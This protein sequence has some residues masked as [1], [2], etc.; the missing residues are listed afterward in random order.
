MFKSKFIAVVIL[1]GI[2]ILGCS[3]KPI[4]QFTNPILAGFYP[5]PSLCRVGEDYYLVTSTFSYF[6]GI[7][8]F[9][10]KDLVNWE[11][12]GHVL[13]RPEQLDTEGLGI[14][15]GIFAPA[16]TYSNGTFYVSCTVVDGGGNFIVTSAKPE[17][18]Y[19]DPIWLPEINGIDPS[20]YFD[21]NGKTYILYNSDAPDNKPEYNGHRTIRM[22]ELEP[23]SLK[24]KGEEKIL[25]NGGSDFSKK[26]VWI[27]GPHFYKRFGYYYLMAAEGGTAE[28]HSEVIFRSKDINGPFE[29][30]KNNPILTQ[31]NL[32]PNR[33]NPI[34][35]TGHAAL[36]ETPSGEWWAVF[37]GCRPYK[38]FEE[39]NYNLGRETFLAPV[40]WIKEENSDDSIWPIINPDYEEVQFYYDYPN[41][42]IKGKVETTPYS[43]NFSLK[44]EFDKPELNK[45]FIFL[46]TPKEKWYNL[47]EKEN[48]LTINLRPET[49]S[50]KL[51]PSFI[52]YRQQHNTCTATTSV[53]FDPITQNEKAGLVVIMNESHFYFIC[54]SIEYGNPVVQLYMGSDSTLD[55]STMKL[56]A[57]SKINENDSK[58]ELQLRMN[59]DGKDYSFQ[60][61]FDNTNWITLK[62]KVDGTY[63][64]CDIPRDFVGCIIAMYASS[65]GESSQNKAFYNWFEY[66]GND[67]IYN[68]KRK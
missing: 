55:T 1:I 8:I 14:S 9:H 56:I 29:P 26:P 60:Y 10:S 50:G 67:E 5:D 35:S 4:K 46:R 12:I 13:D 38:P 33:Q 41:I 51:N 40:R 52:G 37:L 54:K 61:S 66:A 43:G 68:I 57:S 45:N 3:T 34:T 22:L 58:K 25:I 48:Y 65:N 20:V 39:G 17:G 32:E 59:A 15:R 53:I 36:V 11:L 2:L 18:P 6:P 30:Y 28:D 19:S 49:C 47:N 64:K 7:P 27:E 62:D 31:R 23:T 63:L 16:I 24:A 42:D 21:D 44:Y